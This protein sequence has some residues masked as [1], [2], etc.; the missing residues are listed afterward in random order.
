MPQ[1]RNLVI[2]YL[3]ASNDTV[4]S[5]KILNLLTQQE[6]IVRS[7]STGTEQHHSRHGHVSLTRAET[8]GNGGNYT[9]EIVHRLTNKVRTM[10]M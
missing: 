10:S 9:V 5:S 3:G 4:S 1:T 2:G 8:P 6:L 7:A